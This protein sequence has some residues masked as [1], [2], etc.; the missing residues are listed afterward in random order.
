MKLRNQADTTPNLLAAIAE[1]KG[2]KL[3][4]PLHR[5]VSSG[6]RDVFDIAEHLDE[7]TVTLSVRRPRLR[8]F[9][10]GK[11]RAVRHVPQDERGNRPA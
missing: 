4:L 1:Q 8:L 9:R 3:V 5:A 11:S 10:G 6:R 7:Q 2:L